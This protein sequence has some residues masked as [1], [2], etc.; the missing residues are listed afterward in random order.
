MKQYRVTASSFVPEG[1]TGAPDAHMDAVE[2]QELR[3]LAGL[4]PLLEAWTDGNT[5]D[6]SMSWL[7]NDSTANTMSPVGSNISMTANELKL[8]EK[9]YQIKT[10]SPEWFKL[11][12]SKP[13]LTGEK[14][15][16][17]APAPNFTRDQNK[18]ND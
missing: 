6:P 2:L 13:L 7:P 18:F 8:L 17:D 9:K 10:G 15:I 14:P 4:P 5:Q 12:F 16:G 3:R 11:W 1:E